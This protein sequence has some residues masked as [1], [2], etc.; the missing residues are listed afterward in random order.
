MA[1]LAMYAKERMVALHSSGKNVTQMN[2]MLECEHC[3]GI[4]IKTSRSCSSEFIRLA[5][6]KYWQ[7]TR[8]ENI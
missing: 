2:K 5:I 4:G 3:E 8:R 6:S 7:S 1:K